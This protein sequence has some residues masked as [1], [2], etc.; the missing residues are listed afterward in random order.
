MQ[1]S[2]FHTFQKG[3]QKRREN[4]LIHI[5]S[6]FQVTRGKTQLKYFG[7]RNVFGDFLFKRVAPEEG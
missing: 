6:R 4:R 1:A 3:R 7:C 5:R 2:T